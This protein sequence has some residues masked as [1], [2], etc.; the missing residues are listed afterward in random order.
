M[1]TGA[2]TGAE[3]QWEACSAERCSAGSTRHRGLAVGSSFFLLDVS[4]LAILIL[5]FSLLVVSVE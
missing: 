5:M 3:C 2:V 4:K 1:E